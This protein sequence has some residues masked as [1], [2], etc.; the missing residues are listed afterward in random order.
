LF[1]WYDKSEMFNFQRKECIEIDRSKAVSERAVASGGFLDH[2]V[3]VVGDVEK[4]GTCAVYSLFFYELM[5]IIP[6]AF[7][8]K[9]GDFLGEKETDITKEWVRY[10]A[11]RW[12]G[13]YYTIFAKSYELYLKRTNQNQQILRKRK[14][15]HITTGIYIDKAR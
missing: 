8:P 4:G 10:L 14:A 9:F 15:T 2:I 6:R 11:S 5:L 1:E 7:N 3:D 12:K 13:D